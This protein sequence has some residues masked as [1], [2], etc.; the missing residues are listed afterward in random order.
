MRQPFL[1]VAALLLAPAAMA[2][3][4]ALSYRMIAGNRAV[5]IGN[6]KLELSVALKGGSMIRLSLQGDAERLSPFGNP[7]RFSGLTEQQQAQAMLGHFV[8]VDGFGPPSAEERAAGLP[9]HGEAHVRPWEIVSAA[10]SAGATE[11]TFTVDLPLVHEMLTRTIRL[12]D[13]ESVVYV[14]SILENGLAFDRPVN[15]GEHLTLGAPFLEPLNTVVDMSG[16]WAKSREY[17]SEQARIRRLAPGREFRW[18]SG[19]ASDGKTF[20]LRPVPADPKSIDHTT[21]LMDRARSLVFVTGLNI[22]RGYL[23]GLIFRREEFPWVQ[24]YEGYR[25]SPGI[26][27]ALEPAT[28]PFD[29]PRREAIQLNSMFD[30]PT[31]LWLPAKAKIARRFLLFYCRTPAGMT[32]VD[33]V[34]LE[35][36]NIIIQDKA[37]GHQIVLTASLP[38]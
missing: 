12:V 14:D 19:P 16:S 21:T 10:K 27:R 15:W 6:D 29:V 22:A 8:C 13:G 9:M 31:Y 18:P 35:D 38:L 17:P 26:I 2:Q 37:G 20:D 11:V 25:T 24:T 3:P 33:D 36:G 23:V 30:T 34:R 32:K 1:K 28:Q 7:E 5:V 4:L